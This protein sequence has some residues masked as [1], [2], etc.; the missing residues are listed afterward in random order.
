MWWRWVLLAVLVIGVLVG[1]CSRGDKTPT[2]TPRPTPTASPTPTT[3]T[4]TATPALTP[5]PTPVSTLTPAPAQSSEEEAKAYLAQVFP[6]G[7][8]RDDLFLICTSCH[9][10][11][12]FILTGPMK[13][14]SSWESARARHD[15]GF[16]G[17]AQTSWAGSRQEAHDLLWEYLIEHFGPDKP[18]PPPMPAR[19]LSGWQMY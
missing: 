14:R 8:G 3:T 6:P 4:P 7:P 18:P 17:G 15:M 11:Q 9:G 19:L 1:A 13:D 2:P 5:T 10:V 16:V 12:L